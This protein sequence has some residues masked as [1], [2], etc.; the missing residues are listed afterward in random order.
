[1]A[2]TFEKAQGGNIGNSL[3]EEDR[4]DTARELLEK[5]AKKG[6]CLHFPS[7]SVIADKFDAAALP[8]MRPA[9]NSIWLDGPRHRSQ[10][11]SAIRQ[12]H[13]RS[14]TI[15][16]NGPMGVFEMDKFQHGNQSSCNKPWL[17]SYRRRRLFTRRRGDSVA[18]VKPVWVTPIK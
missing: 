9:T 5:A 7:D 14:K 12:R 10:C 6:V 15:L 8:P 13:Q 3:C 18:A 17:R 2:Y 11:L 4:I 1:M 16:W